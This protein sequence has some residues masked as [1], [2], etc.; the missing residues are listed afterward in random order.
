MGARI[1]DVDELAPA[2]I[3]GRHLADERAVVAEVGHHRERFLS[4]ARKIHLD[5]VLPCR[6][7]HVVRDAEDP[8]IEVRGSH[9]A[10]VAL[11]CRCARTG[12]KEVPGDDVGLQAASVAPLFGARRARA[13][14]VVD[15]TAGI[16]VMA[17]GRME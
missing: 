17:I 9:R 4:A 12:G 3:P 10:S 13:E 8:L 14:S 1:G 11:E 7:V 2:M 6:R 5:G 15:E 16:D